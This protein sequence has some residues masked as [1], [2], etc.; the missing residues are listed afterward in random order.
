MSRNL[1]FFDV[2]HAIFFVLCESKVI[3]LR[4]EASF[5]S[6]KDIKKDCR[7]L[8][9]AVRFPF[10]F[11]FNSFLTLPKTKNTE[12]L[13][14]NITKSFMGKSR[15]LK[16]NHVWRPRNLLPT[17]RDSERRNWIEN[18][19]LHIFPIKK[20]FNDIFFFERTDLAAWFMESKYEKFKNFIFWLEGSS[21]EKCLMPP[22]IEWFCWI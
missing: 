10:N 9:D 15:E 14:K 1:F 7:T 12:K 22:Y 21:N 13:Y 8:D 5:I 19:Q 2:E 20:H 18:S 11:N 6:I 17:A 16:S 3:K 4:E